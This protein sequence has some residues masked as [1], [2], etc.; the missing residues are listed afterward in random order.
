MLVVED[1]ELVR[2]IVVAQV[3]SLGYAI[4]SAANAAEAVALVN[5]QG[6]HS[7]TFCL[8]T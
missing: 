2:I 3:E 5:R 8:P 4:L 1:D 6:R 7:S